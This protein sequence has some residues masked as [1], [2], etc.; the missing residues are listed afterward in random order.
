[1]YQSLKEKK[2]GNSLKNQQCCICDN[3]MQAYA[4]NIN[5]K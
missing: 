2:K 4:D 5:S 1:M 3:T